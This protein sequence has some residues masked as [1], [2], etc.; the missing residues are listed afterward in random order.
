M[1]DTQT[2][3]IV[4]GLALLVIGFVSAKANFVEIRSAF[5]ASKWPSVDG[6]IESAGVS[7]GHDYAGANGSKRVIF[8]VVIRYNYRLGSRDYTS[9][10]IG[11]DGR[12]FLSFSSAQRAATQYAPHKMIKVYVSPDAPTRS[13]IGVGM[14][15]QWRYWLGLVVGIALLGLGVVLILTRLGIRA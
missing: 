11:F 10:K 1:H 3:L 5:T 8:R 15:W 7:E 2:F 6:E 4:A 12:I 14:Q 13:M 9:D